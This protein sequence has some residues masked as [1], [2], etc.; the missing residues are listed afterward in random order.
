MLSGR[1][2]TTPAD[3]GSASPWYL[4]NLL[5]GY[6][7]M[8][9]APDRTQWRNG[10]AETLFVDQWVGEIALQEM[11]AHRFLTPDLSVEQSEFAGGR[12]VIV[13]Y[14]HEPYRVDGNDVAAGG[15]LLR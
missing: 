13:N 15:H 9:A 2:N 4:P 12:S 10:F 14:G 11:T 5:W 7:T 3:A 8:W 1:H 6:F